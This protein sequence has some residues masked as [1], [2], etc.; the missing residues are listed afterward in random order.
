MYHLTF[1]LITLAAFGYYLLNVHK[2]YCVINSVIA[3]F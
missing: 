3:A 2:L 1:H